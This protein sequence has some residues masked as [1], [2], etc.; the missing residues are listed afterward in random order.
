MNLHCSAGVDDLRV[1]KETNITLAE[2]HFFKVTSNMGL[3]TFIKNWL[4]KKIM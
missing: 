1:K 3:N 4:F 2:F